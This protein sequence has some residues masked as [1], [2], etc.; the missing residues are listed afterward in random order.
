MGDTQ[1]SQTISTQNRRIVKQTTCKTNRARS[2]Q[3]NDD[4]KPPLLVGEVSLS[5]IAM[6]AKNNPEM[7]FTSLSHRIDLSLLKEALRRIKKGAA[8]GVDG[9]M[10]MAYATNLDQNLYNLYQRLRRGQYVATPVKRIWIEKENGKLRPIGIPAFEDKIVQKA[11]EMILSAIYEPNFYNF[12]HGFRTGHSQHM[13]IKELR[14]NCMKKNTNWIVSADITGLFDNIDHHHLR[15]ILKLRVNDGGIIRL[16]GKWLKAGVIEEGQYYLS[17][18]GT[19]QGGVISPVLSNIFLHHVLDDWFVREVQP[20]MKG[21]SFLIRFADDYAAGFEME[22]DAKRALEA[23][24]KRFDRFGLELHPDKTKLIR[25]GRPFV[26]NGQCYKPETFD[27]LG[28][29]F[30]KGVSRRGYWVVLKKTAQKRLSRFKKMVW[31]WCKK[32]R[33]SPLKWQFIT[34]SS[35][36]RGYYQ[37]FGVICNFNAIAKAFH[38]T[39]RAWKY[40]L[41]RRCHK[42]MV[43][44]EDLKA[45]YSLPKPRI[46]HKI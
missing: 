42:G 24:T 37:Y 4:G 17:D 28:F 22:S 16:I 11:V 21:R 43:K 36:L 45:L 41:S 19:P 15:E 8:T 2:M 27:F 30:Y 26:K 40:W 7:T 35:K 3:N 18:S 1:R 13:A 31:G 9:V 29:T 23:M 10:G 38:Y 12:S 20:R 39:L 33:H 32:N 25:F 6:L 44:I 14:E 5:N 46:I 34:L